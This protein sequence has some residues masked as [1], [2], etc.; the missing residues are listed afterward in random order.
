MNDPLRTPTRLADGLGAEGCPVAPEGAIRPKEWVPRS[1]VPGDSAI[2]ATALQ[3]RGCYWTPRR[4]GRQEDG[5][6]ADSPD[7]LCLRGQ[8]GGPQPESGASEAASVPHLA[9]VSY[10]HPEA[11]RNRGRQHN[12]ASVKRTGAK[13]GKFRNFIAVRVYR[14]SIASI[15]A[16]LLAQSECRGNFPLGIVPR[17]DGAWIM[18]RKTLLILPAALGLGLAPI[19]TAFGQSSFTSGGYTGG[20]GGSSYTSGGYT[21]GSG[22]SS[23]TSG[24][25]TGGGGGSSFTSGGYPGGGGS[26]SSFTSGGYTGGSGGSSFTSGGYP[27]GGGERQ[28]SFTSG[29]V[30]WRWR[31]R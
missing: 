5:P 25:Y 18:F 26:G 23:F 13:S 7:P 31:Q 2:A 12:R 20:G 22:G 11:P 9:F 14:T 27:G 21:G 28:P 16:K 4:P 3:L 6:G 8:M 1:P 10:I 19:P 17:L 30:S 24:G 29:G 15:K